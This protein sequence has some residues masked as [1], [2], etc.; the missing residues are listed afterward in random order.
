[1]LRSYGRNERVAAAIRREVADL[2]LHELKDPRVKNATVTEVEVSADLRN[3]RIYISFLDDDAA[4]VARAMEGL[5]SSR[6]FIRSRLA[7]RLK[8]RYMPE[9]DLRYDELPA[10]SVRLEALI[11]KGLGPR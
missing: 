8:L 7:G 11:K 10:K 9:L 5:K 2:L 1:M 4:A 3:A 6:G